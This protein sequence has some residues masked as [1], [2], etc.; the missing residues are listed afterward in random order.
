MSKEYYGDLEVIC[1]FYLGGNAGMIQCE[2]IQGCS[3]VKLLFNDSKGC[4]L[5]QE[6][7]KHS[8]RYCKCNYADCEIYKS[9]NK[10]YGGE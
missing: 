6:R 2:G 5:K 9:I 10:K 1:P 7:E 4:P 8:K 3:S